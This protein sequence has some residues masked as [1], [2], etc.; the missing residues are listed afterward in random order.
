VLFL[1][2]A[3]AGRGIQFV[4]H[5]SCLTQNGKRPKTAPQRPAFP[6]CSTT[7]CLVACPCWDGRIRRAS[8]GLRTR[9]GPAS[10]RQNYRKSIAERAHSLICGPQL[11]QH[12]HS[13]ITERAQKYRKRIPTRCSHPAA[14]TPF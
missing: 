3:N 9:M 8:R 1:R 5:R 2:R 10:L 11:S 14:A 12:Y 6:L 4:R 7:R 13:S